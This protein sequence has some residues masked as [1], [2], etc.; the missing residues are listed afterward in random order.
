MPLSYGPCNLSWVSKSK[1]N[2]NPRGRWV[3]ILLFLMPP[4]LFFSLHWPQMLPLWLR[5]R[6]G[7]LI[8]PTLCSGFKIHTATTLKDCRLNRTVLLWNSE[9]PPAQHHRVLLLSRERAAQWGQTRLMGVWME[10]ACIRLE[11]P[12]EN[13]CYPTHADLTSNSVGGRA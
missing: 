1:T 9:K 8:I 4:P 5:G 10:H 12:T 6:G 3:T 2:W 11:R 7:G 13:F